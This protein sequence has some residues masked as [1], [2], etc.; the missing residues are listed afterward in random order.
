MNITKYLFAFSIM[1]SLAVLLSLTGLLLTGCSGDISTTNT[2]VKRNEPGP[3]YYVHDVTLKD[4]TR[5]VVS[6]SRSDRGGTG[7]DCDFR[8]ERVERP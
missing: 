5:C 2:L 1:L 3:S 6:T 4:G 7:I 8:G